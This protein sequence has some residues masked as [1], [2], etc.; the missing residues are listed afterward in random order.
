MSDLDLRN[1]KLGIDTRTAE[2]E[3]EIGTGT[4]IGA[5]IET[6]AE[7]APVVGKE[8]VDIRITEVGVE[9]DPTETEV[10]IGIEKGI[11]TEKG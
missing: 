8:N 3:V 10:E 11:D 1:G 5:S 9:K 2:K 4:E 6:D 7:I